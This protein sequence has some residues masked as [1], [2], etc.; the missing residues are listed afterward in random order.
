VLRYRLPR[1]EGENRRRAAIA[2]AYDRGLAGT[3]LTLPGPAHAAPHT[4]HQYVV[5]HPDRD[6]LRE[7]LRE[8]GIGT[9]IHYPVPV[10]LQPA[11]A[12]RVELDPERLP[13]TER[14]ARDVVSL[15]MY[16]ELDDASV[17]RVVDALR[18]LA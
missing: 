2:A 8:A 11:Y 15:P 3:G 17:A 6:R 1:L 10:H 18:R 9:N 7:R 13:Q 12:D 16:S 5:R 4:D 14:A